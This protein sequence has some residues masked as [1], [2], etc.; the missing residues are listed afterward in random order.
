MQNVSFR[1]KAEDGKAPRDEDDAWMPFDGTERII[2]GDLSILTDGETV[3]V[4][5]EAESSEVH[6]HGT[7]TPP[8]GPAEG[9]RASNPIQALSAW[10][11]FPRGIWYYLR[12]A[13]AGGWPL[14]FD[15]ESLPLA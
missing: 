7:S 1:R 14:S 5:S 13:D 11:P 12:D 2:L 15:F 3:K 4:A 8:R 6:P 9:R 10:Y